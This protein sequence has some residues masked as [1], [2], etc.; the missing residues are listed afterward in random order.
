MKHC[1]TVLGLI[2][3]AAAF[4]P[5]GASAQQA[6]P[7]RPVRVIVG[8]PAGSATDIISRIYADKL[9]EQF[10]QRFIIENMPGA[11]TNNAAAMVARAEPD[12]Y[13]L[14]VASNAQSISVSLYKKLRYEFPGDFA[15]ISLIASSPTMLVVSPALKVNSVQELI[16]EAKA[17]PGEITYGSAGV[18]TGPQLAAELLGALTGIKLTHV[19]YKGTNEAVAD[20]LTGRISMLF[21]ATPVVAAHIQDGRLKALAMTS[22]KRTSVAPDLPTVAESGVPGFDV[23]LWFGLVAPK[24]T[25]ANV[26]QSVASKVEAIQRGEDVVNRLKTVGA[27]P[28]AASLDAFS[29]FI[30]SDIPKWTKAVEHSGL[31]ID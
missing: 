8:F 17:R 5:A 23:T 29:S 7:E 9:S 15:P 28:K 1:R 10:N 11:A 25:P 20:L 4:M 27:E 21:A 22:E 13:T 6:Y 24:G 14:F 16:K 12:G 2:A 31:K 30:V 3:F 26:L 18:G 19:P